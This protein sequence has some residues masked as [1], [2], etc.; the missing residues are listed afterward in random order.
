MHIHTRYDSLDEESARR[1]DLELITDNIHM[2]QVSMPAG[3]FEPAISESVWLQ[4]YD[5]DSRS[6]WDRL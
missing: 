4:T 6:Y 1:R 3:G 5:L 2:R